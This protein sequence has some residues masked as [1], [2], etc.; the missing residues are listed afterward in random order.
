[1]DLGLVARNCLAKNILDR[2]VLTRFEMNNYKK[3]FVSY[4]HAPPIEFC[5]RCTS[6]KHCQRQHAVVTSSPIRRQVVEWD[7]ITLLPCLDVLK[8]IKSNWSKFEV[9]VT[10]RQCP[11][12]TT[13]SCFA[14]NSEHG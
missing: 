13:L 9:L 1:M 8:H 14:G 6:D 12:A 3:Q 2:S 10:L 4:H 11:I 5:D 7:D